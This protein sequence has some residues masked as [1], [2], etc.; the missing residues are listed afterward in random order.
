MMRL[1][2]FN[3][4]KSLPNTK[5][6]ETPKV[7]DLHAREEDAQKFIDGNNAYEKFDPSPAQDA[8]VEMKN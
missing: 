2:N 4:D 7:F 5:I 3:V 6:K 1:V 8:M